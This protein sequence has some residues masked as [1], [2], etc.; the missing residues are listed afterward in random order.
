[1]VFLVR[2]RFELV[3]SK[4][5]GYDFLSLSFQITHSIPQLA[6]LQATPF[7]GLKMTEYVTSILFSNGVDDGN[8]GGGKFEKFL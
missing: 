7:S 6:N 5:N 4:E 1:M 2:K 3:T 8:G